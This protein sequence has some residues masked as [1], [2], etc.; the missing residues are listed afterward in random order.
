M[1]DTSD[2][3][4]PLTGHLAAAARAL[5]IPPGDPAAAMRR[6]GRRRQRRH[7]GL[8]GLAVVA[9]VA[10]VAGAV[11]VLDDPESEISVATS[12]G[13][14]RG[15]VGIT[16]R[17]VTPES[18]L[19]Y[20]PRIGTSAPLYALSTAAGQR[21][22]K[23]D[24]PRVLWR[25]DDGIEWTAV[26][27]SVEDLFV[28]DLASRDDRVYAVGTGPA[29]AAPAGQRP[30][31]PLMVGWSDDGARTWDRASLPLD[32]QGL[33]SKTLRLNVA[34]TTVASG[35][36]GTV[37]A[38]VLDG[39][40][41]VAALLPDGATA[42]NGWATTA[43]GVDV[44]GPARESV[45]PAGS[46]TPEAMMERRRDVRV[47]TGEAEKPG[48][49][50]PTTCLP[51]NQELS[52]AGRED[53]VQVPPQD[54]RGVVASYTW[55]QLGVDG[56]LLRAVRRQPVAFAAAPGS[57][58]FSRVDLPDLDPV[59]GP[60]LLDAG[61]GGFDLV[62][63]TARTQTAKETDGVQLMVLHSDDGRAWTAGPAS[64]ASIWASAAGR[65]GGVPTVVGQSA[66]G[67]SVLRS[68]DGGW[69]STSLSSVMSDTP[70]GADLS[71]MH[72]AIG[73]FGVV[74]TVAVSRPMPEATDLA[75]FRPPPVD[76]RIL[77][78]RDGATWQEYKIDDLAGRP[79]RNIIRVAVVGKRV[80]VTV[81]V[82]PE[83]GDGPAQL[84]LVGTP[85]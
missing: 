61:G 13:L 21:E 15:D 14:N 64:G 23:E 81:S 26:S 57:T 59:G 16:W 47:I 7:R 63:T 76:E 60:I 35:P 75:T 84:V 44:L 17:A 80:A 79:V 72:A 32:L 62:A 46:L 42:P 82:K 24:V 29:G 2:K 19:G 11:S 41:D 52:N 22:L 12:A 55:E 51:E 67:A 78:S 69:T 5:D 28:S 85:T 20:A 1:T 50:Y 74:A 25:S 65:V 54:A 45:C 58:E 6:G 30:V 56:D 8:T 33:V 3:A 34:S 43:T 9:L 77:V 31:P 49:V 38:G 83:S 37:I 18:G 48:E 70:A 36:E 71:L 39:G 68:S 73:P 10:T 53:F 40:L 4:A 27:S 66:D